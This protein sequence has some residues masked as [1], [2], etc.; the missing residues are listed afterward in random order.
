ML[1]QKTLKQ[2]DEFEEQYCELARARL[3]KELP[4]LERRWLKKSKQL[5]SSFLL[6]NAGISIYDLWM[7][8]EASFVL[9]RPLGMRHEGLFMQFL[10]KPGRECVRK[11]LEEGGADFSASKLNT[12]KEANVYS[13]VDVAKGLAVA[14]DNTLFDAIHP[15]IFVLAEMNAYQ[16]E[17]QMFSPELGNKVQYVLEKRLARDL[18][19]LKRIVSNH[20]AA[21]YVE[22]RWLNPLVNLPEYTDATCTRIKTLCGAS[23]R[24]GIPLDPVYLFNMEKKAENV[25]QVELAHYLADQAEQH[26]SLHCKQKAGFWVSFCRLFNQD[27]Y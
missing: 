16:R 11:T 6:G 26:K 4:D 3:I 18:T 23:Y 1:D 12:I 20:D 8:L 17:H 9:P 13:P 2:M 24:A 25:G 27:E 21:N 7:A 22:D 15:N 14:L 5:A 10:D 19:P